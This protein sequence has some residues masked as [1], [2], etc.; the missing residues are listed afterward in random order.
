MPFTVPWFWRNPYCSSPMCF[1]YASCK[2]ALLFLQERVSYLSLSTVLY[3][4]TLGSSTLFLYKQLIE[5]WSQDPGTATN[6]QISA[7]NSKIALIE[8]SLQLYINPSVF[9]P[10]PPLLPFLNVF[11]TFLASFFF[12][13]SSLIGIF[14]SA[15]CG[16]SSRYSFS[17][18]NAKKVLTSEYFFSQYLHHKP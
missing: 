9:K 3:S 15:K 1:S 11:I 18:K 12:G 7:I 5:Q 14:S 6:S 16:N 8:F 4:L 10:V 17:E 2:W 13:T